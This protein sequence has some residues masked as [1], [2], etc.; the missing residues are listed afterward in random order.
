MEGIMSDERN[1]R[2][3]A[4]IHHTSQFKKKHPLGDW[5]AVTGIHRAIPVILVALSLFIA[6]C[7]FT[8]NTGAVGQLIS[9][10]LLGLFA[11]GVL[12]GYG[13]DAASG[14]FGQAL[15]REGLCRRA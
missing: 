7:Y 14:G 1:T 3:N 5:S 2:Q 6:V 4:D 9:S 13:G 11:G 8:Q 10:L 15:R 12:S